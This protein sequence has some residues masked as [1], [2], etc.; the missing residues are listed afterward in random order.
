MTCN[1]QKVAYANYLF[2]INKTLRILKVPSYFFKIKL[3][4][5]TKQIIITDNHVA[6]K[7]TE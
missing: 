7:L 3:T 2:E 6:C 5:M 1:M 4:K